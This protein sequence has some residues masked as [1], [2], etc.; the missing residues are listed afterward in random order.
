[1]QI[2]I[3]E[4]LY[5]ILMKKRR[6]S[7]SVQD[8]I[9]RLLLNKSSGDITHSKLY[10]VADVEKLLAVSRSTVFRLIKRYQESGGR[11]GLGPV[12]RPSG[13]LRIP[14]S[15]VSRYMQRHTGY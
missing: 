4:D 6:K 15:T 10:E 13:V 11:E 1:M 7:E 8:V 14:E 2:K 12:M 5:M 3:D 9:E